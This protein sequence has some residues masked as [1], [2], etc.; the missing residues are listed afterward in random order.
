MFYHVA[1]Y[2]MR[3][4]TRFNPISAALGNSAAEPRTL[5]ELGRERAKIEQQIHDS[6]GTDRRLRALNKEQRHLSE[7]I[8]DKQIAD[9]F[10]NGSLDLFSR[11]LVK[12][13]DGSWRFELA[14]ANHSEYRKA[15]RRSKTGLRRV[16]RAH[17][18]N[19]NF[20]GTRREIRAKSED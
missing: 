5:E 11:V 10:A 14:W 15:K 18:M 4:L 7:A 19:L 17:R 9:P 13:K 16:M 20:D 12:G 8:R 3:R 2:I 6:A 1:Q